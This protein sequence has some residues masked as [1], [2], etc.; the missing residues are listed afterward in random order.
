MTAEYKKGEWKA[1]LQDYENMSPKEQEEAFY[2]QPKVDEVNTGQLI[3][4]LLGGKNTPMIFNGHQALKPETKEF[5][6]A[7]DF[8]IDGLPGR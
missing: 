4:Y 1:W 3:P 6:T 2:E 5:M 8:N 7:K